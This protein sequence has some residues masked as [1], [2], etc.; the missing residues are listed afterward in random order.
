MSKDLM[1]STFNWMKENSTGTLEDVILEVDFNIQ[2]QNI[3]IVD[4]FGTFECK[5]INI[6]YDGRDA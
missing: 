5:N 2:D 1:N 4:V 6:T 3:Q